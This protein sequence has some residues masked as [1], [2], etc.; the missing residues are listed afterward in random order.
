MKKNHPEKLGFKKSAPVIESMYFLNRKKILLKLPE[1]LSD[2][3]NI[4]YFSSHKYEIYQIIL[5]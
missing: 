2:R 5:S 4:P 3:H 1:F